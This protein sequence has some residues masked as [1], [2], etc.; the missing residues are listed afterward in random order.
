MR[1]V[2]SGVKRSASQEAELREKASRGVIAGQL[3]EHAQ[4]VAD[5]QEEQI[6]SKIFEVID[7]PNPLDQDVAVQAWIELRAVYKL[8]RSF[9]R[10]E[11]E[12]RTAGETL[13]SLAA[14]NK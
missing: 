9:K 13:Q 12:G 3:R 2:G 8:V 10:A 7:S 11:M 6:R 14:E 5:S 1:R 4:G